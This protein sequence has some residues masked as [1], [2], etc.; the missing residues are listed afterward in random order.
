MQAGNC[1]QYSPES[2]DK[3]VPYGQDNISFRECLHV[4]LQKE[5]AKSKYRHMQAV[6]TK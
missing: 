6:H 3:D 5:I 2:S 1:T 4:T